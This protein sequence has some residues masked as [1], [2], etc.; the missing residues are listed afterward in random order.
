MVDPD[1]GCRMPD[2]GCRMP[3]LALALDLGAMRM[4]QWL[5][6]VVLMDGLLDV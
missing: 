2:A 4:L 1:A 6:F 3:A 5:I